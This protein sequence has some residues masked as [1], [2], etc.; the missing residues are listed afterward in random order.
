[1]APSKEEAAKWLHAIQ[2]AM[3]NRFLY[4]RET[5]T[6]L[7]F[8]QAIDEGPDA[9]R[10]RI[11]LLSLLRTASANA[12]AAGADALETVVVRNV[13]YEKGLGLPPL[14]ASDKLLLTFVNGATATLAGGDV[15]AQAQGGGGAGGGGLKA[16]VVG[17][18]L[19]GSLTFGTTLV[20]QYPP[21]ATPHTPQGAAAALSF[22][23]QGGRV[24][25]LQPEHAVPLLAA[26][27]LGAAAL[28]SL[29][30]RRQQICLASFQEA[31]QELRFGSM[32]FVA[33]WLVIF[34]AISLSLRVR[35]DCAEARG[36][37]EAEKAQG[38]PAVAGIYLEVAFEGRVDS[39]GLV[40]FEFKFGVVPDMLNQCRQHHTQTTGGGL[41]RAGAECRGS[42][43]R[44]GGRPFVD[45]AGA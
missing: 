6:G 7:S 17:G 20:K 2:T 43:G 21:V 37:K 36:M 4:R 42:R 35:A 16:T 19:A 45:P 11:L 30:D 22:L 44:G 29:T 31:C 26:L 10:P 5:L 9:A 41:H 14:L 39:G 33:L 13:A 3:K 34:V 24:L 23:G 32:V 38:G 15:I 27:M 40:L 28:A 12:N 8:L 18:G 25:V 1:M